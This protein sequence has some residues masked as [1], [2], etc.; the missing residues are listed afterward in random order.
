MICEKCRCEVPDGSVVCKNCGYILDKEKMAA[1]RAA[2][3]LQAGGGAAA[4]GRPAPQQHATSSQSSAGTYSAA[5][6]SPHT[7]KSWLV[8]VLLAMFLGFLGL[9]RFY[10]GYIALGV[11]QLLTLGGCGIWALIDFIALCFDKYKDVDGNGFDDYHQT[12]GIILFIVAFTPFI[13][14][15]LRGLLGF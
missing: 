5:V 6:S 13:F 8:S 9:H 7:G 4:I 2:R 15:L 1:I 3:N 14:G 12:V 11:V 10:T